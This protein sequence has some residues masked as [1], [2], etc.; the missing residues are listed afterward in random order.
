M[1]VQSYQHVIVVY[2]F[3]CASYLSY[4]MMVNARSSM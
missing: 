2:T 4:V 3:C 1:F